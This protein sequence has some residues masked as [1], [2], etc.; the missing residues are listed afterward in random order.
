MHSSNKIS[1]DNCGKIIS[2]SWD[3]TIK[4]WDQNSGALINTYSGGHKGI[5]N[6]VSFS[7]DCK[8]FLSGGGDLSLIWWHIPTKRIIRHITNASNY[9]ISAIQFT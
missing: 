5:V 8:S 4:L 1:L 7:Y 9:S 6:S 3:S 2:G